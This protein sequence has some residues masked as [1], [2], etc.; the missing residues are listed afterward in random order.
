MGAKYV[1]EIG[2]NNTHIV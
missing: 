2:G 1:I